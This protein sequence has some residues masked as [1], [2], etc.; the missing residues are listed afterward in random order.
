[1]SKLNF[2]LF[3]RWTDLWMFLWF[4][5]FSVILEIIKPD[6]TDPTMSLKG[7]KYIEVPALAKQ[8]YTVSFFAHREGSYNTKVWTNTFLSA[9]SSA[10][11]LALTPSFAVSHQVTFCNELTGE[12]QF[13]LINFKVKSPGVLSIINL[14]SAVR[15]VASATIHMENPLTTTVCFTS[16]CKCG[17]IS[18]PTQLTVPG[19][20]EVDTDGRVTKIKRWGHGFQLTLCLSLFRV[21]WALST[22]LFN[23][24][25]VRL[26]WPCSVMSWVIFTTICI[27]ELCPRCQRKPSTSRHH[28]AAATWS[29]L[30]SSTTPAPKLI[31]PARYENTK[32]DPWIINSRYFKVW[33]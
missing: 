25:R 26:C 17:D 16:E 27:S 19:Q 23:Q 11:S 28:W 10:C 33:L 5:R 22:C 7:Q 9:G 3:N 18:A 2:C 20:S 14:E 12:Y 32:P 13:Y 15:R 6:K 4:L 8:D 29:M 31:T 1:M 21:L 24:A 30:N